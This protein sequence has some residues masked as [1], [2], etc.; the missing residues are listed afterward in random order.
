MMKEYNPKTLDESVDILYSL[1]PN[2]KLDKIRDMS[3]DNLFELH[4]GLGQW[5][6]NNFGI[7]GNNK[8]LLKSLGE[9]VHPDDV[10][11]V[12]IKSLWTRLQNE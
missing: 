8:V 7:W 2:K 6:R 11:H 5:I 10:S 9:D 12:I 3:K 1:I 4:F